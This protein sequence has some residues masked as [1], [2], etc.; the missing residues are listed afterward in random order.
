M[1]GPSLSLKAVRQARNLMYFGMLVIEDESLVEPKPFY[2]TRHFRDGARKGKDQ[3]PKRYYIGHRD[4]PM[5]YYYLLK[6]PDRIIMHPAVA[7]R[8]RAAI[9]EMNVQVNDTTT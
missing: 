1:N 3:G 9:R 6:N 7:R 5:E 4:K 8:L 2:V